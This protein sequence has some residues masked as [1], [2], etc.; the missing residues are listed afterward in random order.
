MKFCHMSK[1]PRDISSE[2]LI[3]SLKVFD[4][5]PT[6]QT[7][8]HIRLTSHFCHTEHHVTIP[9]HKRIRIGTLHAIIHDIAVYLSMNKDE[10]LEKIFPL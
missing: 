7:G 5:V 1:I 6:R 4:Y 9:A 3:R 10:V 8:S 2:E